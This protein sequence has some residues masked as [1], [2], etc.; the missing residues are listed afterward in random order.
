MP[1]AASQKIA[2]KP[3][4]LLA[5][6]AA[7][8]VAAY[9][10]RWL[11]RPVAGLL[12]PD[13]PTPAT[14]SRL[15]HRLLGPLEA[16]VAHAHRRGRRPAERATAELRAR[17]ACT[18][19]Q[20]D[21][22]ASVIAAR[23]VR[24][25]ALQ[26]R[27]V[28]ASER[29]HQE[30][31]LSRRHF[32]R[33]LG[34]SERTFRAWRTRPPRPP[35]PA[36]PPPPP[37]APRPRPVGRFALEI[38]PPDLQ[39]VADTTYLRAFG[40]DLRLVGTQD[41]GRRHQNLL[42]AFAVDTEENADLVVRVITEAV[43][44]LP[45]AQLLVDQG[46]P[47]LAQATRQ[48]CERLEID[49]EPQQEG[50]PTEKATLERAWSTV[51]RA[52]HPLL[53]LTDRLAAAVPA[54]R[55]ADLARAT[56]SLLLATFLRVY[57]AGRCHL[58]HPLQDTDPAAL[59]DIVAAAREAA[60]AESRSRKL[61][62]AQLHADY[63]LEPFVSCH[64]FIRAHRR[65]PLEDLQAADRVLRDRACR[66]RIRRCDLYFAAVLRRVAEEGR[67]RRAEQAARDRARRQREAEYAALR[68]REQLWT[69]RPELR[70]APALDGLVEQWDERRGTLL[71]GGAGP[72][73]SVTRALRDFR[74]RAPLV[75]HYDA[76]AAWCAWVATSA[77]PHG[78]LVAISDLFERERAR[79]AA[80]PDP[81]PAPP[82]SATLPLQARRQ[83]E[84][85]P[86]PPDLTI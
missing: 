42:S 1:L 16:L 38:C 27:L 81:F 58:G 60:R 59:R 44:A 54:L 51:K 7:A 48:A 13:D 11:A 74:R 85:P 4:R 71:F 63:H 84:R 53:S 35:A 3:S 82:L 57:A 66:C 9:D 70:L 79:I 78:A 10:R 76:D 86:P 8:V 62:L 37:S 50:A 72:L 20:L 45:G 28:A 46:T 18:Q 2:A 49:H 67:R 17:L 29:L 64:A 43:S 21:V 83:H 47:Y 26:D 52:L 30:H 65:Y 33:A 55:R 77:V 15:W 75:W 24:H 69:E 25:R 41:P 61:F 56:T 12:G 23:G 22:A 36:A 80:E 34:L 40:T 31:G 32:C 14:L 68:A 73:G 5:L 6:L 39:A 19:A